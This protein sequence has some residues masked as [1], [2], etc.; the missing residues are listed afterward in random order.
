M[1]KIDASLL[2]AVD[3]LRLLDRLR[4]AHVMVLAL[5]TEK[6]L[7]VIL[8]ILEDRVGDGGGSAVQLTT[9]DVVGGAKTPLELEGLLAG[10]V[11]MRGN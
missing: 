8:I 4:L 11:V 1:S 9:A 7:G 3:Y 5:P 2:G 6:V 10:D